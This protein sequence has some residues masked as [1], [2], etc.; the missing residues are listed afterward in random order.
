MSQ[1]F[2]PPPSHAIGTGSLA[3]VR[4]ATAAFALSLTACVSSLPDEPV[5]L[6]AEPVQGLQPV[7]LTPDEARAI[8]LADDPGALA[9]NVVGRESLE[10]GGLTLRVDTGY[11]ILIER[12]DPARGPRPTAYVRVPGV[13]AIDTNALGQWVFD[14]HG[15]LVTGR[16]VGADSFEVLARLPDAAPPP[17]NSPRLGDVLRERE[18]LDRPGGL[19]REV[20]FE[21]FDERRGVLGGWRRQLLADPPCLTNV[22]GS[23]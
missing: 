8:A 18:P 14:N 19:V 22:V 20:Y 3:C 7:Y 11:G 4:L 1:E 23:W 5:E 12:L 10:V 17:P 21:C 13:S 15:D 16:L 2:P 6:P 9:E